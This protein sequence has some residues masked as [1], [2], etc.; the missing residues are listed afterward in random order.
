LKKLLLIKKF[1][2]I[3]EN[4]NLKIYSWNV[5]GI[6][7]GI[8]KGTFHEFLNKEDPD[9]LCLNETKIDDEKIKELKFDKLLN[10]KYLSY[11]NCSKA[12]LGYSGVAILTK[13]K[14]DK[15]T[16]GINHEEHDQEGRVVTLEYSTFFIVA[17]YV[18]NAGDGCRRLDY[19]VHKWDV[20][21]HEYLD[22]L[23]KVKD[24]IVC[25][26]LN[27]AHHPIDI[28]RPKS[29]EGCSCYTIEERNSFTGLLTRGYVDTFRH[30]YPDVIKYTHFSARL[31]SNIEKNVGWRLD[32]F[33]VNREAMQRLINSEILNE[34]I[35]SDHS[36]IKLTFKLKK[37]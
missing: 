12:K 35:G 14:P 16:Y 2:F 8:K 7:A 13:F 21:F 24:V 32:Y 36:P 19:R 25:G 30:L 11:W 15:V 1:N 33:L 27:V 23:K 29:N 34:Y 10:H 37:E 3:L 28:A 22:D 31:K 26:D 18:P 20:A 4:E 6:R 17:V 5:N 9:I